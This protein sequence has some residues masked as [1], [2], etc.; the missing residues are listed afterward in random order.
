MIRTE[1]NRFEKTRYFP[2]LACSI[3]ELSP[4]HRLRGGEGRIRTGELLRVPLFAH[5]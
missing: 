4:L 2:G 1:I 3:R 5:R